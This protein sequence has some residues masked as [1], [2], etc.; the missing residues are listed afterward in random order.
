MKR[1]RAKR[2]DTHEW[3]E[4]NPWGVI[5]AEVLRFDGEPCVHVHL[6][7]GETYAA[8]LCWQASP[9]LRHYL[10][11]LAGIEEVDSDD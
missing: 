8:R 11:H 6:G 7:N 2:L 4:I 1:I 5:G 9:W 10:R 3:I